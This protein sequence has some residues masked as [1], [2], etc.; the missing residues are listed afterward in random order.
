MKN[1]N[2]RS[3]LSSVKNR[4]RL[5]T[6]ASDC[7][8]ILMDLKELS[9]D[10]DLYEIY[11]NESKFVRSIKDGTPLKK[12]I[13]LFT[14]IVMIMCVLMYGCYSL[15]LSTN[16]KGVI[17][18]IISIFLYLYISRDYCMINLISPD[19]LERINTILLQLFVIIF[20]VCLLFISNHLLPN[21]TIN[22][23]IETREIGKYVVFTHYGFLIV[24]G[25]IILY[26]GIKYIRNNELWQTGII[27]QCFS[28]LYSEHIWHIQWMFVSSINDIPRFVPIIWLI[29]LVP[30]VMWILLF[31]GDIKNNKWMHN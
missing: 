30:S 24:I 2:S 23:T 3:F 20:T 13:G 8:D 1:K 6:S 27:I 16:Y 28:L 5:M 21:M 14:I 25:L 9:E 26:C 10:K 4:I 18:F 31:F 12:Q 29:F 17:F 11:T 19:V 15:N 22:G 7:K